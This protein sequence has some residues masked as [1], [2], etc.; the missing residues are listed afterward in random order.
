MNK[1]VIKLAQSIVRGY[2]LKIEGGNYSLCDKA[3]LVNCTSSCTIKN[4]RKMEDNRMKIAVTYE[5][6]NIF[7]ILERVKSLK[8][9]T[10]RIKKLSLVK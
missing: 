3:H 2:S 6:G 5:D 9:T 4:K 10:L 7:N 1:H 8:Y